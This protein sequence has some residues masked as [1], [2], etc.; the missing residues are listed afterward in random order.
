MRHRPV[1]FGVLEVIGR[2][3]TGASRPQAVADLNAVL[4]DIQQQYFPKNKPTVVAMTPFAEVVIGRLGVRLWI[5]VAMTIA[6]LLFACANVAALRLPTYA[7]APASSRP[8]CVSERR[9][10][11][12]SESFSAKPRR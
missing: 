8:G 11:R 2:L 9:G 7:N 4:S 5:A 6:V 12:C 1:G 10:V 3:K